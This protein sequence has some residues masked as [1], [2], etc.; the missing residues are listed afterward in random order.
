MVH[1]VVPY[2]FQNVVEA[3]YVGLNICVRIGD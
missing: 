2:S 3:D 1:S